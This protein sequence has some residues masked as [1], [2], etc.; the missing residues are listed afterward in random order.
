MSDLINIIQVLLLIEE[1]NSRDYGLALWAALHEVEK[2]YNFPG[3]RVNFR[4]FYVSPYVPSA[5][6]FLE[7]AARNI[8]KLIGLIE[9]GSALESLHQNERVEK[10]DP[11]PAME[12][13]SSRARAYDQNMLVALTREQLVREDPN[14]VAKTS[15]LLI[16][17]DQLII[18]PR[19]W[20]YIIWDEVED[21]AV[22]SVAPLDPEYWGDQEP[23]RVATIKNR[24][25]AAALA[26]VGMFLDQKRCGNPRCYLY[27]DVDSVLTL[28]R[29][30]GFGP[31][32]SLGQELGGRGFESSTGDPTRIDEVVTRPISTPGT[33]S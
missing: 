15:R 23:N 13:L 21:D 10:R 2:L 8:G 5:P 30:R 19:G 9:S 31:E 32:H 7:S 18:P 6:N 24:T 33:A 14:Q 16:V 11:V 29:M 17:T 12:L 22:I 28:D 27:E 26:L 1:R 25:R 3:R 20:R 4:R